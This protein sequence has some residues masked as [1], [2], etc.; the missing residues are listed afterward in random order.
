MAEIQEQVQL[1]R[2]EGDAELAAGSL[3]IRPGESMEQWA[4]RFASAMEKRERK[5]EK[6][7]RWTPL[8]LLGLTVH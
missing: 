5:L 8:S 7:P 2:T 1:P 3:D 6:L 4:M